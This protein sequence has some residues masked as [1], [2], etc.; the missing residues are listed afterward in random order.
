M[1]RLIQL[2]V[3]SFEVGSPIFITGL[4]YKIMEYIM[5]KPNYKMFPE[6]HPYLIFTYGVLEADG[7][8]RA[9]TGNGIVAEIKSLM[10]KCN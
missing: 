1:E 2:T 4:I 8:C 6:D 3:S 5:D 7:L 9:I 10:K